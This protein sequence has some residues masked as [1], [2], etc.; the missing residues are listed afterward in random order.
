MFAALNSVE[1]PI[2]KL[3]GLDVFHAREAWAAARRPPAVEAA[4]KRLAALEEWRGG[5]DYLDG[6]YTAKTQ[7]APPS[8]PRVGRQPL[9]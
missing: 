9:M 1:P 8:S 7:I 4:Q 5:R 2:Q 6:F 3:G